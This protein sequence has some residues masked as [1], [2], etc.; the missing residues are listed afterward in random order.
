MLGGGSGKG[1]F[2]DGA[3]GGGDSGECGARN[4]SAGS[5]EKLENAINV[6]PL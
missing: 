4:S 3:G 6:L 2:D 1:S 5:L